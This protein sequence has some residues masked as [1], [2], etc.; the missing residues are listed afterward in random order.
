MKLLRIICLFVAALGEGICSDEP[1]Y[2]YYC[3]Q[4]SRECNN[5]LVWNLHRVNC[6]TE[7]CFVYQYQTEMP[8]VTVLATFRGCQVHENSEIME[9][10]ITEK[11]YVNKKYFTT[12]NRTLCNKTG[13]IS[14]NFYVPLIM[15]LLHLSARG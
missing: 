10:V 9:S 11:H 4:T 3:H 14:A 1:F 12:C 8:G 6:S 7:K 2:C 15:L 5:G 13:K